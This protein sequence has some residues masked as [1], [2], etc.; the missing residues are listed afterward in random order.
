M[1]AR[2]RSS[3]G[4]RWVDSFFQNGKFRK[5]RSVI[6]GPAVKGK[7]A[8]GH[9]SSPVRLSPGTL[10]PDTAVDLNGNSVKNLQLVLEAE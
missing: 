4:N 9:P 1:N 6:V 2:G 3:N 5:F 7:I 8:L 10:L